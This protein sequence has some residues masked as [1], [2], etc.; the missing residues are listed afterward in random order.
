VVNETPANKLFTYSMQFY[1]VTH[2]ERPID[3]T[4]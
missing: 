3:I 1:Y 4:W 2:I